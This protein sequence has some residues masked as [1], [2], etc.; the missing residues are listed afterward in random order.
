MK[1]FKINI[2][3]SECNRCF[4]KTFYINVDFIEDVIVEHYN[5][6]LRT[7]GGGQFYLTKEDFDRLLKLVDHG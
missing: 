7:R 4:S 2:E 6:I 5:I 1:L 3:G